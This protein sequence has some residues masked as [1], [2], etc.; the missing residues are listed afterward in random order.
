MISAA[1]QRL[2]RLVLLAGIA[3]WI[4]NTLLR[5]R[6][7]AP[8][9]HDEARYALDAR[10]VLAG[11]PVRFLYAGGGMTAIGI[12]GVLAGATEQMLRLTPALLGG[13]FLAAAWYV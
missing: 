1:E 4:A 2:A 11:H 8:L 13:G 6:A 5:W 10:D 9:G 7:G 12:P 3:V